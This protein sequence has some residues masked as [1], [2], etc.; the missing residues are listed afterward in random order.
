MSARFVINSRDFAKGSGKHYDTIPVPELMRLRD[1]LFDDQGSLTY[2]ISGYVD[3]NN[4][5]HLSL[6]ISGTI[7]LSCQRC[8][9]KLTHTVDLQP[10]LLLVNNEEELDL[11]NGDDNIDA[12]LGTSELD[13]IDLIEEEIILSLSISSRHPEGECSTNS[14]KASK[15]GFNEQS[16]SAHPFAV[17]AKF[18]KLN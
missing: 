14:P 15:T 9:E 10:L 17:L 16:N 11:V 12:I 18:K 3:K 6:K 7:N 4:Q 13:V 5:L 2:E 8:L 1:W